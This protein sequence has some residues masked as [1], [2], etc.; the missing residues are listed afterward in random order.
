MVH[1]VRMWKKARP[2][3]MTADQ[4]RTLGAWVRG[5]NTPQGIALR[6]KIILAAAAGA[7]N[8]RIAQELGTRP[9]RP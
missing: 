7:A 8:N 6:A 4:R 1:T 5:R 9:A 2:L 3:S